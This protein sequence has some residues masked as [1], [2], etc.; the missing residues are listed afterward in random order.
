M[1]ESHWV[2]FYSYKG[3][4]GR[5][6]SLANVAGDLV[7]RGNHVLLIDFDL[8]A[9]G[10]DTF[11]EFGLGDKPGKGIVEYVY[12]YQTNKNLLPVR[13]FV[14]RIEPP[15]NMSGKLWLMPAGSKDRE[16]NNKRISIN[17]AELYDQQHGADFFNNFK[18]EI[19]ETFKPDFVFIDSRTGLTDIGGV[20]TLH[21]PDIVVLLF[22]LN[23]Q[24]LSGISRVTKVLRDS[25]R[26]IQT[27][28]V[29]T[30]IPNVP[31][32]KDSLVE[33]R[34]KRAAE[35]LDPEKETKIDCFINYSEQVSLKEHIYTWESIRPKVRGDDDAEDET[36][37]SLLT[38]QY[39]LLSRII[40]R[41]SLGNKKGGLNYLL[42]RC[43]RALRSD[44]SLDEA[45]S[46]ADKLEKEYG[47]RVLALEKI[48]E[49][50]R[51]DGDLKGMEKALLKILEINPRNFSA[52]LK[53]KKYLKFRENRLEQLI[54]LTLSQIKDYESED[55]SEEISTELYNELFQLY[56]Q[57]KNYDAA[58]KY[59]NKHLNFSIRTKDDAV[60]AL[61]D[62]FNNAECKRRQ[63]KTINQEDWEEVIRNF[64]L[65][66]TEPLKTTNPNHWQ[67][68]HIAYACLGDIEEALKCLKQAEIEAEKRYNPNDPDLIPEDIFS[69]TAYKEVP[70]EVF[71][72]DNEKL[73]YSIEYKNQLWDGMKLP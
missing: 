53:L 3:G 27:L 28:K 63:S 55:L 58:L 39:Q 48:A 70:L 14:R 17:W 38:H 4:V 12:E 30:P 21:L 43:D 16:Y 8:E 37:T 41:M 73:A 46:L 45:K 23:E 62:S 69:V 31:R 61:V 25:S 59:H 56:M 34:L 71:L 22:S 10:L 72:S 13:D 6:N 7:R 42:F 40:S 24:N 29:A 66:F 9:P 19:E 32:D 64:N 57:S 20:C 1:A 35:L 44:F 18:A 68:M 36:S 65:A 2:T 47:D 60:T 33:K 49:I 5:T 50:R 54:D 11:S 26:E 15:K 52:K 51:R 67:A